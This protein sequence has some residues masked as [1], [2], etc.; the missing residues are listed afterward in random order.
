MS[1]SNT[2]DAGMT[3]ESQRSQPSRPNTNPGNS[4]SGSSGTTFGNAEKI[5]ADK[6]RDVTNRVS[7]FAG[8][9]KDKAKE[10]TEQVG[11]MVSDIA[12]QAKDKAQEWAT[13]A[14]DAMCQAKDKAQ[15]WATEAAQKTG[16]TVKDLGNELTELIRRYPAPALLIGFGL[17]FMI[18]KASSSSKH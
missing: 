1:N 13:E 5:A 18:A 7:E 3:S 4:N 11:E 14:G 12:G 2:R 17:G 8:Q 16:A 9:A 10:V 6:A 15:E